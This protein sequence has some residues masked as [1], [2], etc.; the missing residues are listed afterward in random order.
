M[1][2]RHALADLAVF[3]TYANDKIV[4]EH[5]GEK[6]KIIV[7][8]G[9]YPGALSAWFRAKYPHIAEASWASSA[10]VNAV[11]DMDLFDWQ[12]YNS[13]MRSSETCTKVIQGL[14]IEYDRL[15]QAKD[16]KTL[17]EIKTMFEAPNLDDGDFAFYYVDVIVG[18]I[19]YGSRTEI[20]EFLESIADLDVKT[21]F[22]KIADAYND[23]VD[24]PDAYDRQH[25]KDPTISIPDSSRAW[26]YQ[27]CTEYGFFQTNYPEIHTRSDIL[28]RKYWDDRCIEVFGQD[29]VAQARETNA[30]LGD[31]HLRGTNI[32]FTNG[33]EDPWRWVGVKEGTDSLNQV[34][35]VLECENCGHCV[36]LY[37][38]KEEDSDILKEVRQEIRDWIS[39][40]L[41]GHVQTG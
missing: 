18:L 14:S 6:R 37:N 5:G 24:G 29:A 31:L 25:L 4:A 3:L 11:E 12:I 40:I 2:A 8:G 15:L 36:D 13:S 26:A 39:V 20:C 33:G 9:S 32:F 10:V 21:Q 23:P 17:K 28:A 30:Y 38:E 7:V 1:T 16:T 22:Q 35:R 34:S 41:Y 27:Y 19:Q